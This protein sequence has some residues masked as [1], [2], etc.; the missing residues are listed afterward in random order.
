[1]FVYVNRDRPKS[2]T[3]PHMIGEYITGKHLR[4]HIP[5]STGPKLFNVAQGKLAPTQPQKEGAP[6]GATH[7]LQDT[8]ARVVHTELV[9]P[10]NRR[11]HL[12]Y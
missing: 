10:T 2:Y 7:D 4:I 1:M 3:G 8:S 5:N 11:C 12:F 9:D 6:Y